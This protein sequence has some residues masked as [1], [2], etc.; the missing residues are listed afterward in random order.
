MSCAIAPSTP[1]V[2]I[3]TSLDDIVSVAVLNHEVALKIGSACLA[4]ATSTLAIFSEA[5]G[6]YSPC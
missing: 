3:L 2:L 4:R 6:I 5:F 1:A